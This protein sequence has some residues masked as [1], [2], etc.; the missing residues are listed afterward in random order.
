M[1]VGHVLQSP[2]FHCDIWKVMRQLCFTQGIRKVTIWSDTHKWRC[3]E[4]SLVPC[5]TLTFTASRLCSLLT[6]G[7]L[8]GK[9][10]LM[11]LLSHS[12]LL[13][14]KGMCLQNKVFKFETCSP[15]S[16]LVTCFWKTLF[17]NL[18]NWFIIITS[19]KLHGRS[20][21]YTHFFSFRYTL[22]YFSKLDYIFLKALVN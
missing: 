3:E 15:T 21:H 8:S 5:V 7:P 13:E 11:T 22:S 20:A 4:S 2:R 17:Y 18:H 16:F 6:Y 10:V 14:N 12:F 9:G 1:V 19:L